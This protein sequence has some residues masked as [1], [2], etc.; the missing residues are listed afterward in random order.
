[1]SSHRV[2]IVDDNRDAADSLAMMMQMMGN[3]ARTAY[4]GAEAVRIARE[5]RPDVVL[6]D[7]GLPTLDGYDAAR[8]IRSE[9][10]G[11]NVVLIAVTG[12]GQEDDRRRSREAGFDHHLVKPVDPSALMELLASCTPGRLT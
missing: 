7:I 6:L 11:T 12:W 8:A 5:F 2:L 1:M 4:D 3:D 9:S 10:W